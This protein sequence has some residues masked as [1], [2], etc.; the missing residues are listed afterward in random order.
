MREKRDHF[1]R[2]SLKSPGGGTQG[3]AGP[4]PGLHH[5][6]PLPKVSK[7]YAGAFLSPPLPIVIQS[8][9][10]YRRECAQ[11]SH[12]TLDQLRRWQD[13]DA[14]LSL[15]I[16][17]DRTAGSPPQPQPP[18]YRSRCRAALR[19]VDCLLHSLD[20]RPRGV[21]NPPNKCSRAP[22]FHCQE[23]THTGVAVLAPRLAWH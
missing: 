2:S 11:G 5:L 13:S 6:F 4:N 23:W 17:G 3:T 14:L 19:G 18:I 15:G 16:L 12:E 10:S 21:N 22:L 8:S 9:Q 7:T 20:S 1:D